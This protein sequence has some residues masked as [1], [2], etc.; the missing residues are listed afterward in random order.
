MEKETFLKSNLCILDKIK[1]LKDQIKENTIA[2]NRKYKPEE[3][4][5]H[6]YIDKYIFCI[7]KQNILKVKIARLEVLDESLA[8]LNTIKWYMDYLN[9]KMQLSDR[10]YIKIGKNLEDIVKMTV[11]LKKYIEALNK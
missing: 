8:I 11:G 5:I 3:K 4:Y 2:I 10:A 9:E 7:K 6:N 1:L